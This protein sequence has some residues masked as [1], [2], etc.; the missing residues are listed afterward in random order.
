MQHGSSLTKRR[1]RAWSLSLCLLLAAAACGDNKARRDDAG[2]PRDAG[3]D[4]HPDDAAP[5][6]ATAIPA[7][8]SREIMSAGGRVTGG[9]MT[10]DVQLGHPI[11]QRKATSGSTAVEGNA[12]VKP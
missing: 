11:D 7:Y 2:V 3:E 5:P 9:T 4:A 6:D 12:A 1:P 10:M 8:P